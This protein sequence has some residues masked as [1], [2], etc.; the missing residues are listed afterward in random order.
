VFGGLACGSFGL[1]RGSVI[2]PFEPRAA[3]PESQKETRRMSQKPVHPCIVIS[4]YH[5]TQAHPISP[6]VSTQTSGAAACVRRPRPHTL[7][8]S[9]SA[10]SERSR[11]R[12]HT[13]SPVYN[14]GACPRPSR[15]RTDAMLLHSSV[16]EP[17]VCA[18]APTPCMGRLNRHQAPPEHCP[19]SS[20]CL[21]VS[22]TQRT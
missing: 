13:G 20:I 10:L 17:S 2:D 8:H 3:A 12:H 6:N 9:V 22:L 14:P 18:A 7:T 19:V 15:L 1:S 4:F 11:N 21:R 16:E 5:R